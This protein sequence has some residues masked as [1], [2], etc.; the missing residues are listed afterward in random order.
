MRSSDYAKHPDES[1]NLVTARNC[2]C[3]QFKFSN[4]SWNFN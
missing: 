4:I 2:R 3:S 1:D